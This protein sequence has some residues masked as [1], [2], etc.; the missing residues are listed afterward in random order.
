MTEK[1]QAG[2]CGRFCSTGTCPI[3]G[4]K[5]TKSKGTQEQLD[6]SDLT[7]ALLGNPNTG[8]STVFNALT[9]LRQHVGNWPGKTV[10]RA[11]GS[12]TI[13]D[14][15]VRIVDLPGA[16]S[17]F[18]SSHHEEIARDFILFGEP[19]VTIVVVDGTRLERNLA[20]VLQTLDITPRVVVALNLMDEARRRGI[21]VDHKAL[22]KQLG[23]PVVP[24]AARFG[25]GIDDLLGAIDEVA[26]S[27]P[28]PTLLHKPKDA[29]D[30]A[31]DEI[32]IETQAA[33]EEAYPGLPNSRWIALRLLDAD[34]SIIEAIEQDELGDLI[35]MESHAM[36][37]L[38]QVK[39]LSPERDRAT[40]SLLDVADRMRNRVGDSLA[41]KVALEYYARA[42]AIADS[43]VSRNVD[44]WTRIERRIDQVL[45]SRVWGIP[46]MILLLFGALWLTVVGANYPSQMLA[47]LT[48][49]WI[50]NY[51]HAGADFLHFPGWLSGFLIDGI[52]RAAAWVFSVMLPP[53]AI[54]F[55]I[56]T[57]LEDLGYLPRVAF[58]LDR[59]FRACG[60]HG[61]QAL[62]MM[63][64][65]GCNAAGV[66]STRII[67]SP[68]ERLMAIVTNN[69]S[70]CNG[71]WPTLILISTIFVSWTAP[72]AWSSLI[73]AA[74]V[75]GV[76]LLGVAATFISSLILSRSVLQSEP[77]TFGLELP[78]YRPPRILQ[79]LYTS[80][81]DRTL[82]VLWRAIL[83][84]APAGA[85][86]WLLSNL[87]IGDTS[88][89]G[90]LVG[91]LQPVG[92]FLGLN[93][94]ILVA[95]VLA[96]PANE[97]VIPTILMLTVT[98]VTQN[99]DLGVQ[100][101]VM[102]EFNDHVVHDILRNGGWTMLTAVNL[103]IFCLFHNPCSTTIL[104]IW[105]ETKSLR[106]TTMSVVVPLV[107]G[108]IL[109][110]VVAAIWRTL[111]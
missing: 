79:T 86:I 13:G 15:T 64:G 82:I 83:M 38:D 44:R 1:K 67:D 35:G 33:V 31:F 98:L 14:E 12:F 19:A 84:A 63:M 106:W 80:V 6:K 21:A 36:P 46:S 85:I 97:I 55:P 95:Y 9:G 58:N 88:I 94:I 23:V 43:V 25:Q 8:K 29:E 16:Y 22:S 7:V 68:R 41:D 74:V 53:M 77:S 102:V 62:S 17:L 45:T 60:G 71:R 49:D 3:P 61:K 11:E 27:D 30:E 108:V 40:G 75:T 54:F 93:G 5:P 110:A 92:W 48:L 109:C 51:L 73:T 42:G 50:P 90:Y 24:M 52:W 32:L 81:I 70:V 2:G 72:E 65:F 47:T 10:A 56:F 107:P 66:V 96:I 104:T 20:L 87:M 78:P 69:F 39:L 28:E 91:A 111:A 89:A 101:G 76:C 26:H 4:I 57:M 37:S 18:S 99:A 105:N 100:A 34:H 103:L 59:L